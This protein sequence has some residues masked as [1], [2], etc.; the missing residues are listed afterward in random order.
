MYFKFLTS[1]FLTFITLD[2]FAQ[3]A[4]APVQPQFSASN[5]V[6]IILMF[7]V[8]YFMIIRPQKKKSEEETKFLSALKKGDE[9]YTKSGVLG[10]ICGLT[11]KVITLEI[12]ESVKIKVLRSTVAG[13]SKQ[14]FEPAQSK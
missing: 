1:L 6:P 5:F 8:F 9:I 4:N 13:L 7:F 11:D 14:V 3:N 2:T 12:A 10:T